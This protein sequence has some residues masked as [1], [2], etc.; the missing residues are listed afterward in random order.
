MQWSKSMNRPPF[1][2]VALQGYLSEIRELAGSV[3]YRLDLLDQSAARWGLARA[4]AN[5]Q[6]DT[7]SP[8]KALRDDALQMQTSEQ[9]EFF[10]QLEALLAAWARLSLL[11][12]PAAPKGRKG[13]FSRARGSLL[14]ELLDIPSGSILLDRDLRNAWMHFD[15]RLDLIIREKGAWGNRHRFTH[16]S[17]RERDG[18]SS[19]RFLALDTL[20]VTYPTQAGQ[21]KT[22]ALR[23]LR[24]PLMAIPKRCSAATEAFQARFIDHLA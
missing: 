18:G 16:S 1:S 3:L 8:E 5:V 19:I 6:L 24:T 20:E 17:E 4:E 12:Q 22:T 10:E 13:D 15:E 14:R 11:L 2:A 7:S 9:L 23:D 21:R